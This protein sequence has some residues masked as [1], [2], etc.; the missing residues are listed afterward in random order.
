MGE[1]SCCANQREDHHGTQSI[2]Q[3]TLTWNRL[4][5]ESPHTNPPFIPPE[6]LPNV[7]N[8][9]K[10]NMQIFINNP[11]MKEF[12]EPKPPPSNYPLIW[13]FLCY[14]PHFQSGNLRSSLSWSMILK[15]N[16]VQQERSKNDQTTKKGRTRDVA[17][18][19]CK[20][21]RGG[22]PLVFFFRF[23]APSTLEVPKKGHWQSNLVTW[24]ELSASTGVTVGISNTNMCWEWNSPTKMAQHTSTVASTPAQLQTSK[25]KIHKD[26]LMQSAK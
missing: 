17:D 20:W 14:N 13:M 9:L 24:D 4:W 12:L 11:S 5:E 18:S 19:D 23:D 15:T 6:L 16:K 7:T 2:T 21:F 10:V 1:N 26:S 3:F 22:T 8:N 25:W